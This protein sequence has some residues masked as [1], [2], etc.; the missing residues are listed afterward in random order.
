ML[1][2]MVGFLLFLICKFKY[3]WVEGI[4]LDLKE[5]ILGFYINVL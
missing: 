5:K 2:K 1:F 4:I 3:I